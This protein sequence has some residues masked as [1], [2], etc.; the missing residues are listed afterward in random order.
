MKRTSTTPPSPPPE[1]RFHRLPEDP[2]EWRLDPVARD[3]ALAGIALAREALRGARRPVGD[4]GLS[5]DS[6][7]HRHATAA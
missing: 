1:Q 3:R 7:E 4:D 2:S 6:D 5:A